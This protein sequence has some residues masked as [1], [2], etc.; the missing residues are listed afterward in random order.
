[1]HNKYINPII[2][3]E[4]LC[5]NKI[6]NIENNHLTRVWGYISTCILYLKYK[7]ALQFY[8]LQSYS[9][10]ILFCRI[11]AKFLPI[12]ERWLRGALAFIRFIPEVRWHMKNEVNSI[13]VCRAIYS[14]CVHV[15]VYVFAR[16]FFCYERCGK[17][18][19]FSL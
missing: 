13:Y 14:W 5:D 6:N 19:V 1:M 17:Y 2:I 8:T 18:S 3:Q 10:Y 4:Q 11:S 9:K 7:I 15:P 16:P 12:H